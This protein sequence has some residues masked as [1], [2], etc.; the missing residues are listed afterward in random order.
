LSGRRRGRAGRGWSRLAWGILLALLV[1]GLLERG[2]P[3]PSGPRAPRPAPSAQAPPG[4]EPGVRAIAEAARTGRSDL[5]VEA[6]GVVQRVLPDDRDGS[7]HQRLVV[8]LA[9][10]QTVLIAHNIDLAPRVAGVRR[11]D[12]VR[13]RGEYEWNEKG[14]VVH[15]T[16]RDPAG[17]HPGGWIEHRGRRYD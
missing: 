2:L 4:L 17:R 6:S 15:W 1:W 5:W 12:A 16:H 9:N 3:A 10:D 8:R 13:F 11:G 14:G 7:R